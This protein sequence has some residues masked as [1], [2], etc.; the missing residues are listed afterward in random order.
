MEW[1]ISLVKE[2]V[3]PGNKHYNEKAARAKLM[4]RD[5]A[6]QSRPPDAHRPA[7]ADPTK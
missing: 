6:K 5:T 7:A 2:S 1:K 4:S 3:T